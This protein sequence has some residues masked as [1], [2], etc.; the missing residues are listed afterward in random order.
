MIS[1]LIFSSGVASEALILIRKDKI[2]K[3]LFLILSYVVIVFT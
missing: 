1:W 2:K 3:I